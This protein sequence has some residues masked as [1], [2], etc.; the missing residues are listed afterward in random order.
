M[1]SDLSAN[2]RLE[3]Q[4]LLSKWDGKCIVD[5]LDIKLFNK[6][7][8]LEDITGFK[9][10][11][12]DETL[13]EIASNLN[14][15]FVVLKL[16]LVAE[17]WNACKSKSKDIKPNSIIIRHTRIY[18]FRNYNFLT[19]EN[20]LT[21]DYTILLN[22][23]YIKRRLPKISINPKVHTPTVTLIKPTEIAI[24]E[25]VTE[26]PDKKII[27]KRQQEEQKLITEG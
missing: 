1:K 12:I 25:N 9:K 6:K 11:G 24:D 18:N 5:H 13:E 4:W 27:A 16:P 7:S 15:S 22:D 26:K 3:D 17:L 19:E 21:E 8:L 10:F 2:L 20:L 23:N 14:K